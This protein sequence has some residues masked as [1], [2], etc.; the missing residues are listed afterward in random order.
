MG[1]FF[2]G[3]HMSN[4]DQVLQQL[5]DERIRAQQELEQ[6]ESAIS[7][8]EGLGGKNSHGIR[9]S[10]RNGRIVSVLARRRMAA[11]QRARWAK[12]RQAHGKP[13]RPRAIR[14]L[15]ADARR[16]I[17]AAQ[18]VRWAKFRAEKKAA[19]AA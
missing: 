11:A 13:A 17:A 6:L 5:R 3:D 4:L 1:L 19:A 12:Y 14:I 8:L 16:R 10:A 15:S 7:A 18:K 9:A 2:R